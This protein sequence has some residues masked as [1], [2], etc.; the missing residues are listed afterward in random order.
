MAINAGNTLETLKKHMLVD[1]F[2]MVLDLQK[3][4]GSMLHDSKHNRTYIDMFTFFASNPIGF[5]HP[6]MKESGFLARLTASAVVKPSN[7]DIYTE[8][9]AHFV[10]TFSRIGIP[11]ELPHLFLIE[12]GALAVENCLKV[13]FDWKT[14]MNLKKG[15]LTDHSLKIIHF[16]QAFHGRSGYTMSL[17][18]TADP[19]KTQYFPKFDWPRVVNPAITFP[20]MGENLGR[21]MRLENL[22]IEMIKNAFKHYGHSVAAIII[23][24]IQA[25]GGDNHFRPEFFAKLR[26]L[27]DENEAMLIF[28]EIQT[29]V[30]LT[31]KFWA[32]EHTGIVPDMLAFGKK[33]QICGLLCGKR[34]E[35]VEDNVFKESSRINSTWGGNLTDMVRS[36]RFLEIIEE[37]K[38]VEHSAETG[39]GLL[40][41]IER[42]AD[43]F[44]EHISNTRGVGLMAAFDCSD[45]EARNK[46]QKR[47][48]DNGVLI[49]PCGTKS[50]RFR[51]ALDVKEEILDRTFEIIEKSVKE[52]F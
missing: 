25:E 32:Y 4:S 19:R 51:P 41:R 30:G 17:T 24:P 7:S 20:M 22:S 42:L 44:P 29:G 48:F 8:E 36:S 10:D 11:A 37:E 12:G 35:E 39:I 2:D 31:G 40:K 18:N 15:R 49:L 34:V 47:I 1:G 16:N 43:L 33:L 5:N 38:L 23:E 14:K 52:I 21:V 27:A 9:M 45:T 46:L 26:E 6:R 28:D 13:A 3:S 50:I